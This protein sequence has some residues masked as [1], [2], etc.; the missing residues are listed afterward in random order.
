MK[1]QTTNT[2]I[3]LTVLI[4]LI[5]CAMSAQRTQRTYHFG[6][7][8]KVINYDCKYQTATIENY[9][10]VKRYLMDMKGEDLCLL[11]STGKLIRTNKGKV[12]KTLGMMS[13]TQYHCDIVSP[14]LLYDKTSGFVA[15]AD[16]HVEP[17]IIFPWFIYVVIISLILSGI[18]IFKHVYSQHVLQAS[19]MINMIIF[20]CFVA[21]AI[22]DINTMVAIAA[23]L[24]ATV[25]TL[26]DIRKDQQFI[27]YRVIPLLCMIVV[28]ILIL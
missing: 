28:L 13:V 6:S 17:K 20:F 14:V 9:D 8:N 15:I 27:V 24:L 18:N 11:F 26:V 21:N 1:H 23:A 19:F 12:K 5:T 16:D 2:S 10:K 4:M 3:W 25:I 7:K 22:I